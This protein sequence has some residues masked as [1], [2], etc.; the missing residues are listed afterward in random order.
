MSANIVQSILDENKENLTDELYLKLSNSLL[1]V[2]NE[3]EGELCFYEATI[4]IP[5]F[6]PA[7]GGTV[8]Y[9]SVLR[10][11]ITRMKK[12]VAE[13]YIEDLQESGSV[14]LC[15]SMFSGAIDQQYEIYDTETDVL[16]SDEDEYE[17][18]MI[19]CDMPSVMCIKLCK[20]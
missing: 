6:S 11:V 13:S 10:T 8:R 17:F 7:K 2:H 5:K 16:M 1:T 12:H 15:T 3:S 4:V 14:D 9:E 19:R 18:N 20:L